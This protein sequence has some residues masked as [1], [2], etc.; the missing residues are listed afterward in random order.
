MTIDA[1]HPSFKIDIDIRYVA[2]R[3]DLDDVVERLEIDIAAAHAKVAIELVT[4]E[5]APRRSRITD[6]DIDAETGQIEIFQFFVEVR[7]T[8]RQ[9]QEK[10]RALIGHSVAGGQRDRHAE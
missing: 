1:D 7:R 5:C 9:S 8:A 4:R 3:L 6:F 10:S 2:D